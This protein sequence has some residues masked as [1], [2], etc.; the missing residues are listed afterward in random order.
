LVTHRSTLRIFGLTNKNWN[1]EF[2]T[3]SAENP[4]PKPHSSDGLFQNLPITRVFLSEFD[5]ILEITNFEKMLIELRMRRVNTLVT[6]D[7]P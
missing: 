4:E 6:P 1:L 7:N 3:A 2:W 5:E